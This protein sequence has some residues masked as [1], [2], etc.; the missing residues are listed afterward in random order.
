MP[1]YSADQPSFARK[2]RRKTRAF[3]H[4]IRGDRFFLCALR[5]HSSAYLK[6]WYTNFQVASDRKRSRITRE[7]ATLPARRV[8]ICKA[9][10]LGGL[11]PKCCFDN[12]CSIPSIMNN[13]LRQPVWPRPSR[14]LSSGGR[15]TTGRSAD[16]R[17]PERRPIVGCGSGVAAAPL[18]AE[19]VAQCL[20][21]VLGT[22]RTAPLQL[23]DN[24]LHEVVNAAGEM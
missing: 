1:R 15:S 12:A 11:A 3:R 22:K 9:L 23:R 21:F 5:G 24:A 4:F 13:E 14:N 6:F 20:A 17:A 19:M 7:Q 18:Q 8:Q 2:M 16:S 10:C